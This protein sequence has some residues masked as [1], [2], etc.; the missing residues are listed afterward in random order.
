MEQNLSYVI[1][2]YRDGQKTLIDKINRILTGWA[3]YHKITDADQAFRRVDNLISI[4]LLEL[5]ETLSPY[6]L[7]IKIIKK[8]FYREL[9]GDYVYALENKLAVR[10]HK[11]VNSI[12]VMHHPVT[13][14]KLH[15]QQVL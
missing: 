12:L 1:T 7:R 15:R 11:L 2:K 9:G 8:Y 10:V 13:T 3:S 6:M 4:L 14:K 5:C